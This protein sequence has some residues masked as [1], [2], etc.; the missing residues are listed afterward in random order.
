[1][2]KVQLHKAPQHV[3]APARYGIFNELEEKG[4]KRNRCTSIRSTVRSFRIV[5]ERYRVM[6][7]IPILRRLSARGWPFIQLSEERSGLSLFD[8]SP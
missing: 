1:M 8:L 2:D 3:A 4:T 7:C 5:S 6:S